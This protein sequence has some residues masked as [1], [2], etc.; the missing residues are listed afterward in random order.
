M[1]SEIMIFI[2]PNQKC[3][4]MRKY[5]RRNKERIVY[6]STLLNGA[7]RAL[8]LFTC[9]QCSVYFSVA[10]YGLVYFW[11]CLFAD[12]RHIF[13][14]SSLLFALHYS[15]SLYFWQITAIIATQSIFVNT[16]KPT[17]LKLLQKR[18]KQDRNLHADIYS[19]SLQL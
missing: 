11:T 15:S 12:L 14:I 17:V 10:L 4:I 19:K 8:T 2:S 9:S 6:L 5:L 7:Q 18:T 13:F 1:V 3:K 16:E